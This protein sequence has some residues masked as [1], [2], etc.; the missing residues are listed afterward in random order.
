MQ[1]PRFDKLQSSLDRLRRPRRGSRREMQSR[2][3]SIP[4]SLLNTH[5]RYGLFF[6]S[7]GERGLM[8]KPRFDK[9]RSSLDRSRRPRR[10]SRREMPPKILHAYS[11]YRTSLC[12]IAL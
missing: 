10:G 9:L 5:R 7:G 2:L 4:P 8:Q 11:A 3:E 6:W 1:K 12:E